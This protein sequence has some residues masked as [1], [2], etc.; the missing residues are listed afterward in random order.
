M[1][2]APLWFCLLVVVSGC[3]H[4]PQS[5]VGK[6]ESAVKALLGTPTSRVESVLPGPHF[7]PKPS[8]LP[9]GTRFTTLHYAD[10]QGQQ[11][12]IMLVAPEV[13]QQHKGTLPGNEPLYVIE[14]TAV[15]K[16]AVF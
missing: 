6:S 7:G 5:L 12:H 1:R 9:V 2:H 15:P 8:Q 10:Y 3:G 11:W 13:Y 4:T 14:V 16:G